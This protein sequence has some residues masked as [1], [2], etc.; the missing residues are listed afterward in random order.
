MNVTESPVSV[1]LLYTNKLRSSAVVDLTGVIVPTGWAIIMV[2]A[3]DPFIANSVLD[4][5]K[6]VHAGDDVK[7]VR[8]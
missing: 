1:N 7:V 8:K 3:N 6:Q 4:S 5:S 2:D